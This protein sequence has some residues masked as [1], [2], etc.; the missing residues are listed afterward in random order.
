MA[1]ALHITGHNQPERGKGMTLLN[2]SSRLAAF[3]LLAGTAA[4]PFAVA[5]LETPYGFQVGE[6]GQAFQPGTRDI[7]GNR[8]IVDGR[9]VTGD[10]L[11]TFSTN[12]L[13]TGGQSL[14][15]AGYFGE[16]FASSSTNTAIGNQLNVITQG[17]FNTVIVDSTQINNGNQT[18]IQNVDSNTLNGELDLND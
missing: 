11:S 6:A 16:G 10:D 2:V 4:T 8:L 13:A 9:I 12:T 18:A 1:R 14:S 3:I 7:N 15:G 17:S 5:Q